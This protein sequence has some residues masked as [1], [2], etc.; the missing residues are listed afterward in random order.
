LDEIGKK[1]DLIK[2]QLDAASEKVISRNRDALNIKPN[3]LKDLKADY[4]EL[5]KALKNRLGHF[6]KSGVGY[7]SRSRLVRYGN[8]GCC[9]M[10]FLR[11]CPRQRV[12]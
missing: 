7:F 3:L 9:G 5:R 6:S 2:D 10:V 8:G 1:Y 11:I 12:R 4:E